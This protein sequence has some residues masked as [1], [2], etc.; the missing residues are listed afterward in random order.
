[1]D[2]EQVKMLGEALLLLGKV[3]TLVKKVQIE[4]ASEL[5]RQ[6]VKEQNRKG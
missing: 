4:I 6:E 3:R 1:M 5:V 2:E